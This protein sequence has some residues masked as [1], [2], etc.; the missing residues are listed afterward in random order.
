MQIR[1]F[2]LFNRSK[3]VCFWH[4]HMPSYCS[5]MFWFKVAFVNGVLF[6]I[7]VGV[8]LWIL[9]DNEL[10]HPPNIPPSPG[11]QP[12]PCEP[13]DPPGGP[14]PPGLP[15][16]PGGQAPPRWPPSSQD[17]CSMSIGGGRRAP[18]L[19]G[20]SQPPVTSPS[21]DICWNN[22]TWISQQQSSSFSYSG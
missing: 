16:P 1:I 21:S 5:L 6:V 18:W 8:F 9:I 12:P 22:F 15:P 2:V 13:D 17:A 14:P 4:P 11:G 10:H 19:P 3:R 7:S 20:A